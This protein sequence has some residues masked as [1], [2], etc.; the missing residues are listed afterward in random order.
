MMARIDPHPSCRPRP[1][2]GWATA[3]TAGVVAA[4]LMTSVVPAGAESLIDPNDRSLPGAEAPPAPVSDRGEIAEVH[5]PS[6]DCVFAQGISI[7]TAGGTY[8]PNGMTRRDQMASFIVRSLEA[9]GYDLP[10][11]SDQGFTDIAGNEHEGN[12][13]VLAAI[14]VT[15]GT[16]ETTYTPAQLVR[17]DQMASFLV[18]AAEYAYEGADLEVGPEPVPAFSD[19]PAS[20][21]HADNVNTA[22]LVVGVAEGQPSGSYQ[23]AQPVKRQQ[24]AS[25]LVRLVDM[26]LV[27][28]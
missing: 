5:V 24:M 28:E 4:A 8:D 19:V 20:N 7:G 1:S 15:E 22:A 13:Q 23:P 27:V 10:A 3:A 18:R 26:T 11:P 14:G 12:I 17:R 9:A 16:T 6:V 2:R 21:T 25:F